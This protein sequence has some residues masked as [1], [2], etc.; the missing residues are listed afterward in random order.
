MNPQRL[1]DTRM[2]LGFTQSQMAKYLG[3]PMASYL[4]WEH[5]ERKCPV[6]LDQYL[7]LLGTVEVL[8]APTHDAYVS[9]ARDSQNQ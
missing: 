7:T 3:V 9:R 8:Y 6:L 1:R 5:G 2:R 4:K